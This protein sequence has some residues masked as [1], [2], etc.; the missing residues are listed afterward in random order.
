MST[1]KDGIKQI[2][3]DELQVLLDEKKE[4]TVI[5]DVREPDEYEAAHIPSVPL[6]PMHT[7]PSL[8]EGFDKN[9]EYIFICRSGNRSQNVS[10]FLKE[11]GIENV[12]NFNGGMLSWD[13]E[14]AEGEETSVTSVE[15]LKNLK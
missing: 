13:G 6:M 11:N 7:V 10:L 3:K 2:Y 4:G 15:E 8:V 12:V 5:I 1:E 9:K 14:T